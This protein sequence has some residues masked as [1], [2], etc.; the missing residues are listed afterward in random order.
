MASK[1]GEAAQNTTK[2]TM[3]LAGL[4]RQ[5]LRAE[6]LALFFLTLQ[7]CGSSISQPQGELR[8]H[9][10]PGLGANAE[11]VWEA[12]L[13]VSQCDVSRRNGQLLCVKAYVLAQ[14]PI[15]KCIVRGP[16]E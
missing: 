10:P 16:Y 9:S 13:K 8:S 11:S 5:I 1:G 15:S 2:R 3:V 4:F 14:K 12:D 7:L 6:V